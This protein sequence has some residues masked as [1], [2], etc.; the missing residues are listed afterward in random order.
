MA[1]IFTLCLTRLQTNKK[2]G[3]SLVSSWSV[4]IARY[5]AVQFRSQLEGIQPNLFAMLVRGV[6][7]DA[8][9]GVT[10]VTARKCA[11]IGAARLL[12]ECGELQAD[13]QAF[14]ALLQAL[15]LMLLID[16]GLSSVPSAAAAAAA[17]EQAESAEI[18]GVGSAGGV[19]Y[20]AA[21]AALSFAS[22]AEDKDMYPGETTS[23]YVVQALRGLHARSSAV[24]PAIVPPMIAGLD[25]EKQQGVQALLQ[26]VC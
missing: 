16:Q 22:A 21:Y 4:Y 20:V 23:S 9:S 11:A 10:G 18:D 2:I 8:L 14:G 26:N 13:Q 5:G 19:G 7:C 25:P 15:L 3:P 1:P 17:E 12:T 24:L 6:F